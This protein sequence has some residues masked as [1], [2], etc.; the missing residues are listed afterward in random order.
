MM[1][2]IKVCDICR[3]QINDDKTNGYL[4]AIYQESWMDDVE[5]DLCEDCLSK[6]LETVET[7]KKKDNP[8]IKNDHPNIFEYP[9]FR[10]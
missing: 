4:G 3:K 9:Y 1:A 5:Y 2:S 6:V 8:K 10:R 7:F